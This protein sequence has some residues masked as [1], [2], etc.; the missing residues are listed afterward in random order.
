MR[1]TIASLTIFATATSF[2]ALPATAWEL[3]GTRT[4]A[5]HT[6]EGQAIPLGTVSFK[7]AQGRVAF[8]LHLDHARFKDY[9]LSM[10]EFK[11][12]DGDRELL[13][14]VPYP[15]PQPG[16][17]AA[18]DLAWL[19]HALLFLYKLPGEF[20]ARLWNGLIFKLQRGERGLEGTP[21]AVDLNLISA[22]PERPGQPPYRAALRDE[23]PAGSR[24]VLRLTIE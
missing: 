5:L 16:T 1:P 24:W 13:C 15:Y 22:P 19:E 12:L 21:Q 10:K 9:F 17:V 3:S 20:G 23:V 2:L 18:R 14:H 7:P 8:E 4:I 11:C 6:R